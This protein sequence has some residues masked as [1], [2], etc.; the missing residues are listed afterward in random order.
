MNP[1]AITM[2]D[3]GIGTIFLVSP[4][5]FGQQAALLISSLHL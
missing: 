3:N 5:L 2:E 1:I 4:D